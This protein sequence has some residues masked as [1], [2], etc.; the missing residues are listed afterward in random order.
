MVGK[1]KHRINITFTKAQVEWL[2]QLSKK[3]GASIS[4]LV[5]FLINKDL[6]KLVDLVVLKKVPNEDLLELV[7]IAKTP[8]LDDDDEDL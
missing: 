6:T 1:D 3:T 4:K 2:T 7:R 8:W 5:R